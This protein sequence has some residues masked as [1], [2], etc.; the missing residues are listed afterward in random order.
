MMSSSE[1]CLPRSHHHRRRGPRRRKPVAS[2]AWRASSAGV[3]LVTYSSPARLFF[4][5]A[6]ERFVAVE[7]VDDVVSIAPGFWAISIEF[8]AVGIG[9]SGRGP[10]NDVPNVR[11]SAGRREV[12]RPVWAT[13]PR[14]CPSRKPR[15]RLVSAGSP[16]NRDTR[17][18]PGCAGQGR[19]V[20]LQPFGLHGGEGERINRIGVPCGIGGL[21]RRHRLDRTKCPV[22]ALFGE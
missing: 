22:V 20:G 6:V 19:A 12:C 7:C 15:L 3:S 9:G 11:R 4:D 2:W 5:E 14:R 18:G 21:G 16:S 8:E 17:G 10:A 13:R 1:S